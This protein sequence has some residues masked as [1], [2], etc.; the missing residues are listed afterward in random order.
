MSKKAKIGIHRETMSDV[1][2]FARP[3]IVKD[4]DEWILNVERQRKNAIHE[5]LDRR[6][7]QDSDTSWGNGAADMYNVAKTGIVSVLNSY[8]P[9]KMVLTALINA[10]DGSR[11][12]YSEDLHN[13][14][15]HRSRDGRFWNVHCPISKRARELSMG[16]VKYFVDGRDEFALDMF[17]LFVQVF[18]NERL[19]H[20]HLTIDDMLR[21]LGGYSDEVFMFELNPQDQ[22]II[23]DVYEPWWKDIK[24]RNV[25]NRFMLCAHEDFSDLTPQMKVIANYHMVSLRGNHVQDIFAQEGY[26]RRIGCKDPQAV[27]IEAYNNQNDPLATPVYPG[28]STDGGRPNWLFLAEVYQVSEQW[29]RIYGL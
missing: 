20:D 29:C 25:A 24:H 6:T 27:L 16:W 4:S 21:A 2:L 3:N 17:N 18:N 13:E 14:L 1:K 19:L 11:T 5:L 9:P 15:F 7:F 28:V 26:L 23:E 12:C 22:I 8:K 10:S